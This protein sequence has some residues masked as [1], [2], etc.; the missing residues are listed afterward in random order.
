MNNFVD[1]VLYDSPTL[2]PGRDGLT[3]QK[4]IDALYRSA[5]QGGI[6]IRI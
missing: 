3:V 2:A 6:E 5:E 4:M 1:H